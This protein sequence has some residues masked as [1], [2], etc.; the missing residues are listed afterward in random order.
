MW[1]QYTSTKRVVTLSEMPEV[2][3]STLNTPKSLKKDLYCKIWASSES[4]KTVIRILRGCQV[5]A[6]RST[7][8]WSITDTNKSRDY[9]W[10][11]LKLNNQE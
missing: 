9:F 10:N 1:G 2:K 7:G 8:L 5:S 3:V 4:L 11:N 6:K